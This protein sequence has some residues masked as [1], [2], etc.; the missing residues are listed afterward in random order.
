MKGIA[1]LIIGI[2]IGGLALYTIILAVVFGRTEINV[3]ALVEKEV[4]SAINKMEFVKR[5]IP[6][7]VRYSFYQT[8]YDLANRGGYETFET[9]YNCVPYWQVFSQN[10]IPDIETNLKNVFLKIFSKYTSDLSDS[11]LSFPK[12]QVNFDKVA[13]KINVFSSDDIVIQNPSFYVL[14]EKASF[15]QNMELRIFSMSDVGKEFTEKLS[16]EVSSQSSYSSALQKIATLQDDFNTKYS[17][18]FSIVAQPENNLGK[19]EN[20]FAFRTVV[21]ITDIT[22]NKYPVFDF[23]QNKN[24]NTNLKLNF[25]VLIGKDTSVLPQTSTCEVIQ[26]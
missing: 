5:E 16:Q 13:G 11:T 9:S 15:P 23:S 7:A 4:L 6:L 21:V 26:Y 3:R 24:V 25:Y 2:I 8:S 22:D 1:P 12:F 19:D 20:N 14:K 18:Q 10:N 17:G